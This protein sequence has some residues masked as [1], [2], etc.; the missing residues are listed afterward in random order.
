MLE[1]LT[2]FNKGGVVL[3]QYTSNPSV[4]DKDTTGGG[5]AL[6]TQQILQ[7]SWFPLVLDPATP[8]DK[9]YL[10]SNGITFCWTHQKL[11]H[12]NS[13]STTTTTT[14][15]IVVAIYPD[16]LFEGPRQYLQQ[17]AQAL[18]QK[19]AQE[20][21]QYF[22]AAAVN[23]AG[24]DNSQQQQQEE[25]SLE[26]EDDL[27]LLY[28]QFRAPDPEPFD[29]VFRILLD[30]SKTQ[31]P[32]QQQSTTIATPSENDTSNHNNNKTASQ[33]AKGKKGKEKRQ[34]H[35]G[36]AKVTKEAMEGLDMSKK[37][38]E[39]DKAKAQER[40]LQEARAA[41]LPTEED[42]QEGQTD[43]TEQEQQEQQTPSALSNF[44]A[45]LTGN[46]VLTDAD[47]DG[48]LEQMQQLLTSKNVAAEIA[49]D[50]C[51]AVRKQLRNKRLTQLYRVQTA[52]KQALEATL[53]QLLRRNQ[54]DLLQNVVSKRRGSSDF[55]IFSTNKQAPYVIVVVGINGV[56][57]YVLF[58]CNGCGWCLVK[59]RRA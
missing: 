46:K 58:A 44:F 48:P 22:E 29:K 33:A 45:H 1:S 11:R 12:Q 32:E 55:S 36:K 47:L 20:Y 41:Y 9:T 39:Q 23:N 59:Q 7:Q 28:G 10:I 6:F 21:Q 52:V 51:A 53:E 56:G 19:T 38:T 14:D 24:G 25:P 37:E 26:P 15:A 35:D 2:I 16:I 54:V 4:I 8:K 5:G 31:R 34:W 42:L 18:V 57:K 43:E 3:Y 49:S 13:E 30:Q 40:A 50:L 27:S 17:W